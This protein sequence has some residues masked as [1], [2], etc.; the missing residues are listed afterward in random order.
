MKWLR[1]ELR[2][3]D[4]TMDPSL[5]QGVQTVKR[6]NK[7]P[8][9]KRVTHHKRHVDKAKKV[10]PLSASNESIEVADNNVNITSSN[11]DHSGDVSSEVSETELR[12]ASVNSILMEH[13]Y[14]S[15]PSPSPSPF[16][17]PSSRLSVGNSVSLTDFS[18]DTSM[19][20]TSNMS[21]FSPASS[22]VFSPTPS[23]VVSPTA[24]STDQEPQTV[25]QPILSEVDTQ[26][27]LLEV[28]SKLFLMLPD[29]FFPLVGNGGIHVLLLGR[30]E[31][32]AVQRQVI[33]SPS[34]VQNQLSLQDDTIGGYADR[35]VQIVANLRAL[36]ICAGADDKQELREAWSE[37]VQGSIQNDSFKECRYKETFR[38]N[39][40]SLLV[41]PIHWRC[42]EC[43]RLYIKI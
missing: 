9:R 12:P 19:S 7:I 25:E 2:C 16:S 29:M 22:E 8:V 14:C 37:Y 42:K 11:A 28:R 34:G 3:F 13:E 41:D 5:A 39:K 20:E 23:E 31:E 6:R 27:L 17:R 15:S 36:K 35:I 26:R 40:C 21:L 30:R 18:G 38:S 4:E 33:M 1:V 24:L 10:K 32:K 43:T